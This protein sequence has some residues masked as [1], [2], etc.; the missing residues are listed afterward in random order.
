MISNLKQLKQDFNDVQNKF[1]NMPPHPS[2]AS[3]INAMS[4]FLKRSGKQIEEGMTKV[5]EL[6]EL[7]EKML[8]YYGDEYSDKMEKAVY[9]NTIKDFVFMFEQ[10]MVHWEKEKEKQMLKE[11]R[12][13]SQMVRFS[14]ISSKELNIIR[15]SY[16]ES[17]AETQHLK[18]I[19]PFLE[20]W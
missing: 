8:E 12:Q 2:L 7:F 18:D 19:E 5:D 17:W 9:I 10:S 3:F 13:Q 11:R 15:Y 1:K 16:F 6:N 4:E 14:V 20:H